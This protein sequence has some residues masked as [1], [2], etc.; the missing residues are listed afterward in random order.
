MKIY[1]NEET[2]RD[3]KGNTYERRPHEP[4]NGSNLQQPS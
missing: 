2:I 4:K 3:S 1:L